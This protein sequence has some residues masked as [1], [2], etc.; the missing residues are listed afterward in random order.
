LNAA[1][2]FDGKKIEMIELRTGKVLWTNSQFSDFKDSDFELS[3]LAEEGLIGITNADKSGFIDIKTG[4]SVASGKTE[5]RQNV[6]TIVVEGK[7][8]RIV[9]DHGESALLSNTRTMKLSAR[10]ISTGEK[11]WETSFEGTVIP[12]WGTPV[13]GIMVWGSGGLA[14]SFDVV[15]DKAIVI[16]EGIS[17]FDLSDGRKL[18]SAEYEGIDY[19]AG[20]KATQTLNVAARLTADDGIYVV[21][22]KSE[23]IHKYELATGKE[24][25]SPSEISSDDIVPHMILKNQTLLAQFGGYLS[26]QSFFPQTNVYRSEFKFAGDSYGIRAYNAATGALL[27]NTDKM[28]DVLKEKFGDRIT[29]LII[30]GDYIYV[31]GEKTLCA[32]DAQTGKP[33]YVVNV[34]DLG[35][36]S[37]FALSLSASDQRLYLDCDE[38]IAAFNKADGSKIYSTDTDK[39]LG[40]FSRGK[41]YFAWVGEEPVELT[42]FIGFDLST[43]AIKG[44]YE[45]NSS[46]PELTDDGE[47]LF[48]FDD[49]DVT[50][51]FIN[52]K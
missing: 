3:K 48:R 23:K 42:T 52:K 43:G 5:S 26:V 36:G 44:K 2:F 30:D 15:G 51:F 1:P 41:N 34:K 13:N 21:D 32:L 22:R 14:I 28:R 31:C 49:E 19:S 24:L 25:W 7:D 50:K 20:L 35:I 12:S 9:L 40:R 45:M 38:G 16:Y 37:P 17:V 27:W 29:D 18:W 46:K 10:K 4:Q 11:L 39:N 6:E 8:L 47:Y 33:K